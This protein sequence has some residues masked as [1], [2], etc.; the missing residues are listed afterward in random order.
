MVRL[1][2]PAL[3]I[4]LMTVSPE[5]LDGE[6]LPGPLLKKRFDFAELSREIRAK[7]P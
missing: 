1:K 5:L 2:K 6:R 4:I 7:L 3:P